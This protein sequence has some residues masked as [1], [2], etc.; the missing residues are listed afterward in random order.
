MEQILAHVIGIPVS[1]SSMAYPI[2]LLQ[3]PA[4]QYHIL[5]S[6]NGP[7]KL[8]HKKGDRVNKLGGK[9][10][11]LAN[12][13]RELV[14]LGPKISKIVKG[15]LSLGA[16]IIRVG[17]LEK[18][19]KHNFS[20]TEG[21]KLLKASQCYLSTTAGPI[22]GLLFISTDKVAFCSDRSIKLSSPTGDFVRIRYK[23]L[24]PIEKILRASESQNVKRPSQKYIEIVTV[25]NFD[26]WFMGFL[27][28]Q[29][30]LKYLEQAISQAR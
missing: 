25:D 28:Y 24:I 19:F 16:K 5:Y 9:A 22:A 10:D 17:G 26:F 6:S 27:N 8:K 3:E 29:K 21:E 11:N 30:T 20:V 12:G 4:S 2:K 23:V 18:I 13:I 1:S 14:R 7:L 15:K